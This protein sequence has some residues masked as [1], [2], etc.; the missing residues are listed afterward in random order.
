MPTFVPFTSDAEIASICRRLIDKTLP[1]SDWTHAAHFAAALYRLAKRPEMD[2]SCEMPPVIRAYNEATGVANTDSGGYH[3][4]I[5]L[6]SIRAA[7]AFLDASPPRPLF[8][9]CNALVESPFGD[10]G[11]LLAYWSDAQLS[12]TEARRRWCAPDRRP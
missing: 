11:W 5:T 1:K 9:T 12:S 4:T 10:P 8:A 6:A 3:K 7:R 2:V